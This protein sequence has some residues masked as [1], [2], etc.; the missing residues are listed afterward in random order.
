MPL[1]GAL[2][3][4]ALL[5]SIK[6]CA[7]EG[8]DLSSPRRLPRGRGAR[9]P[10][11]PLAPDAVDRAVV[12]VTRDGAVVVRRAGLRAVLRVHEHRADLGK[13]GERV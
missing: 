5:K 4:G 3:N 7:W 1:N 2:L 8:R 9:G 10:A 6:W 11:R 13:H 12:L